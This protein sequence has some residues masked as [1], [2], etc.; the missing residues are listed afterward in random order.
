VNPNRAPAG[1]LALDKPKNRSNSKPK[2]TIASIFAIFQIMRREIEA[3]AK[4]WANV[5]AYAWWWPA[6]TEL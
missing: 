1:I 6:S 4:T 3:A 5:L 2:Q